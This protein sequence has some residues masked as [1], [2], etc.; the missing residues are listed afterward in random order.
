MIGRYP[1]R[2]ASL[3]FLAPALLSAC[4]PA[5]K[6]VVAVAVPAPAIIAP[7]PVPRIMPVRVFTLDTPVDRIAADPQGKAV[8]DRD[9]PGLMADKRYPMFDDMS[10][11]EIAMFSHGRLSKTKL[12]LVKSDLIEISYLPPAA[13]TAAQSVTSPAQ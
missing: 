3:A 4:S 10:L 2:A 8:L 1:I 6:P 7:M 12:D 9:V 13:D 11:S 5:P